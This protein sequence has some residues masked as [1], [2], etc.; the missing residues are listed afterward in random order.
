MQRLVSAVELCRGGA[1]G[2]NN[3]LSLHTMMW[4][5]AICVGSACKGPNVQAQQAALF[6][7][8]LTFVHFSHALPR[9]E[10]GN[11]TCNRT[12]T[13]VAKAT[14]RASDFCRLVLFVRVNATVVAGNLQAAVGAGVGVSP[15][16]SS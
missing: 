1:C 11:I 10:P 4:P 14:E 6:C 15:K 7:S 3:D 5:A 2:S 16:V 9:L 12:S 13:P 8:L